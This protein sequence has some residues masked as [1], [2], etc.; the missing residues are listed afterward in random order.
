[1]AESL[2]EALE[3]FEIK[4]P[5]TKWKSFLVA[6]KEIWSES[7]IKAMSTKLTEMQTQFSTHVHMEM[8]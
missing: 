6:L 1:M 3:K 5:K 4:G 8:K 7:K 2:L